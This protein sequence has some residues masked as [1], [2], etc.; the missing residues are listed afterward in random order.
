M[1]LVEKIIRDHIKQ[2]VSRD[3]KLKLAQIV[4]QTLINSGQMLKNH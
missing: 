1:S 3:I 2:N 4:H